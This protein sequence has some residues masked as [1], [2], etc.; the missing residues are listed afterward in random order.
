MLPFHLNCFKDVFMHT[1][2]VSGICGGQKRQSNLLELELMNCCE[3]ACGCWVQVLCKNS[4]YFYPLNAH[5]PT[6]K[7]VCLKIREKGTS[8]LQK[9][10]SMLVKGC[11]FMQSFAGRF[12]SQVGYLSS[13]LSLHLYQMGDNFV[14]FNTNVGFIY[15][16]F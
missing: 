9:V 13:T 2:C 1:V 12:S 5:L 6:P 4:K 11:I 16:S 8:V 7:C 14:T 3:L 10:F 15:V